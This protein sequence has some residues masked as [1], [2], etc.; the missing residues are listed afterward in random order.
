MALGIL[1]AIHVESKVDVGM[2]VIN[3]TPPLHHPHHPLPPLLCFSGPRER[4]EEEGRVV[5]EQGTRHPCRLLWTTAQDRGIC[6][7]L[8]ARPDSRCCACPGEFFS[9]QGFAG[10]QPQK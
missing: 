7:H 10:R 2:Q 5:G 4:E 3:P 8:S 1:F 9:F 6:K